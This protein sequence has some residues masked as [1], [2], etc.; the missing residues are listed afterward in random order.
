M[1]ALSYSAARAN[2]A[3]TMDEV[4]RNHNPVIITK[5]RDSAVVMISLE[6]YEAME[7]TSYLMRSPKNAKRLLK[8]IEEAQRGKLIHKSIEEL[9]EL[10]D[11]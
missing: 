5:K 9:E 4:C 7:E 6:D 10:K 2:L 1:N 8:S 3:V 11:A